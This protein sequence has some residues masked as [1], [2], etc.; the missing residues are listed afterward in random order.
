MLASPLQSA[1]ALQCLRQAGVIVSNTESIV[2]EWLRVAEGDAFK[3]ISHL[4]R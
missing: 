1:Y 4:I 2:F 3:K